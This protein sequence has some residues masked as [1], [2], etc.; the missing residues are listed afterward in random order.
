MAG[1]PLRNEGAGS[2]PRYT[3]C[4]AV[5]SCACVNSDTQRCRESAYLAK[6]YL[7][8]LTPVAN[9]GF[10]FEKPVLRALDSP[11]CRPRR[12]GGNRQRLS[13][14]GGVY[15]WAPEIPPALGA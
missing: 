8:R 14:P 3:S 1:C 6:H 9:G 12:S 10:F 2:G 7:P 15:Y 5:F 13:C 4:Q 11:M